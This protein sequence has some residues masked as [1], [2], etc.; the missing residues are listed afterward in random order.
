M[1]NKPYR[2]FP[3]DNR[4]IPVGSI[5]G[6]FQFKNQQYVPT[7]LIDYHQFQLDPHLFLVVK[8]N[9]SAD[10]LTSAVIG[11]SIDIEIKFDGFQTITN[12]QKNGPAWSQ[13]Y[14]TDFPGSTSLWMMF[15][16]PPQ[17]AHVENGIV[18]APSPLDPGTHTVT[19]QITDHVSGAKTQGIFQYTISAAPNEE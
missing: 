9:P 12:P 17:A 10:G 15:F 13:S 4:P 2:S 6:L 16:R 7:T 11:E 18:L 3:D 1:E 14:S 8:F 5:L 19:V